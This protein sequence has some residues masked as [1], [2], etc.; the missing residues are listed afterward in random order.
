MKGKVV[1]LDIGATSIKAVWL[2]KGARGGYTLDAAFIT[3]A[4]V[5]GMIS[6]SPLDQE[7]MAKAIRT[8]ISNSHIQTPFANIA[9][10][11]NQ[12]YTRVLEMPTLTDKELSSAIYWEAEQYIPV[13]LETMVLDWRVLNR[14]TTPGVTSEKMQVLLVGAPKTL[15]ARYQKA[16]SLA[17]VI[18]H[19][20]E[21]E[22]LSS[23]RALSSTQNFPNS[24]VVHIGAVSTSL[25]I[26]KDAGIV[27]TYS[28]PTG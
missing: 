17:S 21:T 24:L 19:V 6:E 1:G 23:I 11:E 13:P 3:P 28:I 26:V 9:L 2:T 27:F 4:P 18:P 12:V 22:I 8:I 15:I 25:A 7:E 20:V 14:S 16:L 10:P 5:K